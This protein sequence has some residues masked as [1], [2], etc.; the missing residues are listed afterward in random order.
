VWVAE[1]SSATHTY[2]FDELKVRG[3]GWQQSE[4]SFAV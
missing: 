1:E 3:Q 4:I 2:D